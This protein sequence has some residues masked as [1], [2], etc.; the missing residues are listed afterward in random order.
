MEKKNVPTPIQK[1]YKKQARIE[2]AEYLKKKKQCTTSSQRSQLKQERA[3]KK[4]AWLLTLPT[5]DRKERK[6]QRKAH[7][8]FKRRLALTRTIV[9]W[10]ATVCIV[11]LLVNLVLT[12]AIGVNVGAILSLKYTDQT[13]EAAA[14]RQAGTAFAT[15]ISDE[16]IVLLKNKNDLLPLQNK[17]INIFGSDA[18][19]F[20]Y[21][22]GGSGAVDLSTVINLFDALTM[23]GIEYNPQLHA[24]YTSQ[25]EDAADTGSNNVISMISTYLFGSE[26]EDV[27]TNDCLTE[28]VLDQARRYSDTALVVLSNEVVESADC[29]LEA[30]ALTPNRRQ[31][32]DLVARNFEHVIVIVNVGNA[33]ELGIVDEYE[34]IEAVVWVG[35]P[36][37]QGCISLG[38]VLTGQVN[39]SGRLVDTYAYSAS[40]APASVNFG[41]YKYD[42]MDMA[43][44]NYEEGIYVGYRY[45]ETRY[46]G[47]RKGYKA[48]VQYPFGY[49]LSYTEFDWDTLSVT[50]EDQQIRWEVSVTNT[51]EMA[52]KDVV[53][54]YFTP[55]YLPGGTEKSAIELATYAKTLSFPVRDMSSFDMTWGT[56]VLDPGTYEIK[57]ARNVHS[58]IQTESFEFAEKVVYENDDTTGTPIGNLFGYADGG[59]TYLSRNDW[60]GTYPDAADTD[61]TASEELLKA[62]KK[63]N[64]PTPAKGSVTTGAEN[65]ILLADLKGLAYDDPKWESFLDQFTYEELRMLFSQGGWHSEA[66]ERLGIPTTRMLD[67]PAGINSMMIPVE[68]A[69]YPS[70]IMVASTWNDDLAYQLGACIG[71]EA[72]ACDVQVWSA[73]AMNI[74]RTAQGGRNFEYYSEDPVLSGKMA[75]ATVRGAQ[76]QGVMVTI[77]HFAMNNEET[78]ARSGIYC[79]ANE[80][81]MR[82]LYLR[83]FEIA[84]KE[85]G[86]TGVMSAFTH[87]GHKWSG[88]NPELLQDLLRKEWGF[89]G[90]V[91][92]DAALAGFMNAGLACRSGNDLMLE[93]GLANSAKVVDKAYAQDPA[94]V[95]QGLR[96]CAHNICYSVANYTNALSR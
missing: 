17:K 11:A 90:L 84:V 14:A 81:A 71:A 58:I 68:A 96:S 86:A 79:W 41:D 32:I 88:A 7:K 27:N 31:L 36:G 50:M 35:I 49:G 19:N 78:N 66:I 45:Y 64:S 55:P 46:L 65:G 93:M 15:Q 3:A 40:S 38:K 8:A 4:R 73:P 70:E 1:A 22:G 26:T 94:G 75:A 92:T 59:L 16:G 91:S 44:I 82:E 25:G 77:K 20:K 13:P 12:S 18:Y 87:I 85:G 83:P 47:D 67:G 52:G 23:A 48:A 5:L 6:A 9:G 57:L 21:G 76:D 33:T 37:T 63:Y 42:N 51:G 24:L 62:V 43:F 28:E 69:A 10:T 60:D 30:L 80:Q 56:Y 54:L 89:T 74:H 95:L 61:Y 53:Q 72:V 39:P 34:S 2:A 29:S